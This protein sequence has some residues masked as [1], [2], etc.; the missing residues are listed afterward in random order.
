M[1]YFWLNLVSL[2]I[3]QLFGEERKHLEDMF[4]GFFDGETFPISSSIFQKPKLIINTKYSINVNEM[5]LYESK[6]REFPA[7]ILYSN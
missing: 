4:G 3:P 7:L 1:R 5:G 6:L 2:K